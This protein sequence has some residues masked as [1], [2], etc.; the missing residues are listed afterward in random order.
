VEPGAAL[1]LVG[2]S[3]LLEIAVRDG[4]AAME[5]GLSVGSVVE[6]VSL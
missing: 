6:I 5:L 1:A 3:G 4:S 2:S